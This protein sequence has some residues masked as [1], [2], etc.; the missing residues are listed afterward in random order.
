MHVGNV[1][2]GQPQRA[3]ENQKKCGSEETAN[4]TFEGAK[5]GQ[6][7]LPW[8][9]QKTAPGTVAVSRKCV[10]CYLRGVRSVRF[11]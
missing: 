9:P 5:D 7:L 2:T 10:P 1:A 4:R 6:T 3:E 8:K 11:C